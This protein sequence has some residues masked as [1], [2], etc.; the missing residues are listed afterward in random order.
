[1]A[2]ATVLETAKRIDLLQV[3]ILEGEPNTVCLAFARTE[4]GISRARGYELLK[5]AM[6][7][8]PPY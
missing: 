7:N 6:A 8:Q 5:R 2:R 3:M 1:M 4:W